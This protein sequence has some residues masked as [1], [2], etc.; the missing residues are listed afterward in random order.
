M[1][2]NPP[3]PALWPAGACVRLRAFTLIELLMVVTIVGI[4]A[5]IAVVAVGRVRGKAY[6]SRC[7]SNV[8]QLGAASMLF[9]A[10]YKDY[11]PDIGWW[12][13]ELLPYTNS[14][15]PH[16]DLFWC[17][18]ANEDE[19]PALSSR[20]LGRY[21]N[22]DLIPIAYGINANYPSNDGHIL[23]GNSG[24]RNR[25]R[26]AIESP[27]DVMLFGEQIGGYANLFYNTPD[28][29]TDRHAGEAGSVGMMQMN[30]VMVDGS[31]RRI[32]VAYDTAKGSSWRKLMDPR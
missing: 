13:A 24:T 17:P 15:D 4:L 12:S 18:S 22:G 20:S 2:P 7:L 26:A 31:A 9:S 3:G 25:R 19:N 21:E 6:E 8:R 10:D 16:N 29:F 5:T 28:R 30:M 32:Q 23:S 27:S 11:L 14:A 1:C